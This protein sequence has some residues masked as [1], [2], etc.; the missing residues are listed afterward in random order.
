MTNF[1]KHWLQ[2]AHLFMLLLQCLVL[3]VQQWGS[4]VCS[5]LLLS[6]AS[7][8]G[9]LTACCGQN[10]SHGYKTALLANHGQS[11]NCNAA[12]KNPQTN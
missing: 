11:E 10:E 3:L 9:V 2:E 5:A 4:S 1:T 6:P 12:K 8:V 7:I